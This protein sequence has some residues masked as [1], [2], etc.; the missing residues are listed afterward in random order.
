MDQQTPNGSD[1]GSASNSRDNSGEPPKFFR[2]ING[3]IAGITGVVIALAG[4]Y[5][6][7]QRFWPSTPVQAV[8]QTP[9]ADDSAGAADDDQAAADDGAAA[10]DQLPLSYKAVDATFEKS[11][12]MWVYASG[13]EV[14]RYQQVSRDD[15]TTIVFDPMSKVYARWPKGGGMVEESD[16]NQAHWKDSFDIWLPETDAPAG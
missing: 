5:S 1:N 4:L 15:G 6:A 14:N 13:D 11:G 3:W 7:V 2:S 8:A 9:P 12:G 16:D 10:E